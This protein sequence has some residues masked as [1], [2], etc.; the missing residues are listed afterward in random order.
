MSLMI[1]FG[2]VG[3]VVIW[4]RY[5]KGMWEVKS[6]GAQSDRL[7]FKG[8]RKTYP[9]GFNAVKD[10]N[11]KMYTGQIF[12][13]L[14]HNGAGKTTVI[15][16][17]TGLLSPTEGEAQ[18]FGHDVFSDITSVREFLGVCPQHNIL[19]DMLTPREHLEIFSDFKGIILYININ[20]MYL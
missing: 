18:V 13:L 2:V 20:L 14:G 11:I 8:L 10:L 19:F 7:E 15:S 6:E 1:G 17:L 12:A 3:W 4:K 9:N 16:M 5:G